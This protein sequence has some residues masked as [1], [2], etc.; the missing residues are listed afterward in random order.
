M[1]AADSFKVTVWGR[2]GHG[3]MPHRSVDPVVL[4]ANVVLRLQ[5]IVSREVNPSEMCVVTV[6]SLQAGTTEKYV[7]SES[8]FLLLDQVL[9]LETC[10]GSLYS[11]DMF[12]GSKIIIW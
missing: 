4:A 6:G 8:I 12:R 3:S 7:F 2:G 11:V 10:P 1:G 5:G 9:G